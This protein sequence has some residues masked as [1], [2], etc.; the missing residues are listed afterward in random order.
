[1]SVV[2]PSLSLPSALIE[3]D[4]AFFALKCA[5]FAPVLGTR[6]TSGP[7]GAARKHTTL[8]GPVTELLQEE[9]L[10]A[11]QY[12]GNISVGNPGQSFRVVF[13]SGSGELILPSGKCDD[14]ACE[15]HAHFVS[16]NSKSAV[17]IGWA[18]DP[19][20]PVEDGDDRDTKSLVLAGTDVS[21]EYV[22]D[23]VCVGDMKNNQ[24]ATA[25]FVTLTEESGDAFND[26]G[27]DG[28][29]GLAPSSSDA[30]EF[31]FLQ[32]F[33]GEKHK[34]IFSFYLA[35]TMG[36]GHDG[37]VTFGG[38]RDDRAAGKF[39]WVKVSEEGTW[40]IPIDDLV[41]GGK[42]MG[43]CGKGGCTAMVDT[44]ASLIMGPGNLIAQLSGHMNLD[45]ECSTEKMSTI[46]FKIGGETFDLAPQDYVERTKEGCHLGFMSIAEAKP[47]ILLGYPFLRKYYTVFDGEQNRVGFALAKHDS[48]AAPPAGV[49][50]VPLMGVRP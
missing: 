21:G 14:P 22:R 49:A 48:K 34:S 46:G 44:A 13:D 41:V 18:D 4:M 19:K 3:G 5:L 25:D 20:K 43:L 28:V 47:V 12:Y 39:T 10:H 8:R 7:R 36:T 29:F 17:Q 40:H 9:M 35:P 33:K 15:S 30:V 11:T 42:P 2:L 27:F 37:E 32:S 24:C 16:E 1:M 23:A 6:H 31:N 50:S 38:Y 45:D 26:A